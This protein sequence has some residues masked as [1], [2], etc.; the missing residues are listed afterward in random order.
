[1]TDLAEALEALEEPPEDADEDELEGESI[2]AGIGVMRRFYKAFFRDVYNAEVDG[3]GWKQKRAAVA[4]ILDKDDSADDPSLAR[5]RA[6]VATLL[7]DISDALH[8]DLEFGYT[9]DVS[10]IRSFG[11]EYLELW[12]NAVLDWLDAACAS[13]AQSLR[14]QLAEERN[15]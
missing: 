14:E 10:L 8:G 3:F 7:E 4:A 15:G 5:A 2:R 6:E 11:H 12:T 1:M 9:D 13:D